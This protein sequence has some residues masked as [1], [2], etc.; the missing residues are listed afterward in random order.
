VRI[1]LGARVAD[2]VQLIVRDG[3]GV[4][5]I[6]VAFGFGVALAAGGALA[7]LLFK[8]SPRDPLVFG[9]VAASLIVVALA[10]SWIPA[11]RASR[12]DPSTALRAD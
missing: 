8:T 10:A 2:V 4:V 1:A 3:V 12:V 5:L 11:L 6:G 7:P 9:G